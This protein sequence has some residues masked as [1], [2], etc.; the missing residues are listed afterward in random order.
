ML[1]TFWPANAIMLGML[2]RISH[3]RTLAG[4]IAA[5]C[6]YLAADLVTGAS[7]T[8]AII[9]DGINLASVTA[10]YAV[11]SRLPARVIGLQHPA[12]V[13]FLLLG[14]ITG[15]LAGGIGGVFAN[16]LLFGASARSGLQF[17]FVTELANYLAVL[18][19]ILSAPNPFSRQSAWHW[20]S[21]LQWGPF[22]ALCLSCLA[23][24][25]IGGAGA[26]VFIVPAL[27]WCGLSY[28][29]FLTAVLTAASSYWALSQLVALYLPGGS[30]GSASFDLISYRLGVSFV[31]LSPIM[32]AVTSSGRRSTIDHF[33]DAA[34][35]D[36]LTRIANRGAF[37]D[38]ARILVSSGAVPSVMVMMDID[39]FKRI[40]DNYGHVVGDMVLVEFSRRV[41]GC[42]RDCD[43]FGRLGGEEFAIVIP[44]CTLRQGHMIAERIRRAIGNEELTLADGRS[45]KVTASIG[46]ALADL[47]Q[48][49]VTQLL[50]K[51]DAAL[52]AAKR[53]GRDRVEVFSRMPPA[54][55]S[56][57]AFHVHGSDA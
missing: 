52:Y 38:R 6:A 46:V 15:S 35:R 42:L 9:L 11:F 41:S 39:H 44:E 28:S 29:V 31:A 50:E 53:N 33:K 23:G 34:N 57:S 2:L 51:A 14:S 27:L 37:L 54:Q 1:A 22:A 4:W 25:R 18:P 45:I 19:L 48:G 49:S 16:P 47:D 5:F 21:P 55:P 56:R 20:P 36:S 17:W 26:I 24:T 7:L 40:N 3:A 12:S 8:K 43:L 10:A 30:Q 32:Q 13:P